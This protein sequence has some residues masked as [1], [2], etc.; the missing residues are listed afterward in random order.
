L[1]VKTKKKKK[2]KVKKS[3][4]FCIHMTILTLRITIACRAIIQRQ[5]SWRIPFSFVKIELLLWTCPILVCHHQDHHNSD[6]G[7]DSNRPVSV[8][9]PGYQVIQKKANET[10]LTQIFNNSYLF[11]V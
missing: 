11:N 4:Q 6:G 9:K 2:K 3:K 10:F 5:F 1:F 8:L 7:D